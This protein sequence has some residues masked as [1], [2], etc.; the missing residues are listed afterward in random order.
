MTYRRKSSSP[1]WIEV[2]RN[3]HLDDSDQCDQRCD[4]S[5]DYD[6]DNNDVAVLI[7]DDTLSPGDP[8]F[9]IGYLD[10]LQ[11]MTPSDRVLKIEATL[12]SLQAGGDHA[13]IAFAHK[14]KFYVSEE[15]LAR[16][17]DVFENVALLKHFSESFSNSQRLRRM[18]AI[19]ELVSEDTEGNV[20]HSSSGLVDQSRGGV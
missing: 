14:T 13:A 18:S 15:S 1:Q 4:G 19:S 6:K 7:H 3:T 10:R 20:D 17:S 16:D 8:V 12:L 11:S 2:S 9:K 5:T